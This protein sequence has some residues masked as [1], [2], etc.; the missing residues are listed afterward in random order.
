M[1]FVILYSMRLRT[2]NLN[3]HKKLI[4]FR[5]ENYFITEMDNISHLQL[6]L[7]K[8][9][10]LSVLIEEGGEILGTAL[11]SYDGRRGYIQKVVTSKNH[12][13]HGIGKQVVLDVIKRL[14]S[15][16]A[17]YVPISVEK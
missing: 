12:R 1:N 14:K 10:D 7:E 5:E 15:I 2:L 8:N 6:L 13:N 16:G 3:D 9:P 4:P 17:L 11:G